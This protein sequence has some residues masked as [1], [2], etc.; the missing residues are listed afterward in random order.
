MAYTQDFH[1]SQYDANALY[2]N[3][4]MTGMFNGYYRV[5]GHYRNQ[6][7]SVASP[8][9]TSAISFD[10]PYKKVGIG[11]IILDDRAGV[12]NYNVLNFVGSVGYDYAIDSSKYHHIAGGIQFGIIHKSVNMD[13]LTFGSQYTGK[14]STGIDPGLPNGE[15]FESTSIVL[16]EL[17]A[18]LLYYYSNVQSMVN[19]FI[20]FSVFHITEPNE[21][22]Y[23]NR[24]KLPRRYVT[25]VGAKVN[26]TPEIQVTP[27]VLMMNEG[28]ANETT[29]G[30]VVNYF[31]R[32]E[33]AWIF[34]GPTYRSFQW[35]DIGKSDAVILLLGVKY[36]KL[37]YRFSYD[38]NT[39]S[40]NSISKGKGGFELSITYIA[41]R[42][43]LP[44]LPC[45]RL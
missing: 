30:I 42:I 33:D 12:G 1:L 26:L 44:K 16:P 17:A 35:K 22:F 41:S 32:S 8:F 23:S 14:N 7:S 34:A 43:T 25:H 19:P 3:P 21:S 4:S 20:G 31:L 5:H 9:T 29:F 40:L 15:L 37:T 13:N 6:W 28:N 10:M 27:K 45:P 36:G 24:N 18:G 39:S 2:V 38:F 11:V